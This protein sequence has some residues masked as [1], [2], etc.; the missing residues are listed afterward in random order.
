MRLI[1]FF[2][3]SDFKH[4]STTFWWRF[5]FALSVFVHIPGRPSGML[6]EG[7]R[8]NFHLRAFISCTSNVVQHKLFVGGQI[9]GPTYDKRF[10]SKNLPLAY[11]TISS[12]VTA[13]KA[14]SLPFSSCRGLKRLTESNQLNASTRALASGIKVCAW[15]SVKIYSSV[16][17]SVL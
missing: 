15:S 13:L 1:S 10:S 4:L 5:V 8:D 11:A 2:C 7:V 6:L 14:T 16:H 3:T 12:L 17:V 9:F